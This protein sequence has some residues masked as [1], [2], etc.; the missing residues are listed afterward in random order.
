VT[1]TIEIEDMVVAEIDFLSILYLIGA[2]QGLFFAAALFSKDIGSHVANRYLAL[3]LLAIS[4]SLIDEFFFQSK[5]FIEY[6]HLIGLVWPLDFLYGP[7]FFY[8]L[9]LLTT[10]DVKVASR[11]ELKHFALFGIGIA[12]AIPTWLMSGEDK[13][14]LLYNF[15]TE[16]SNSFSAAVVADSIA[17]LLAI[18]QMLIYLALSFH[19]LNLHQKMMADNFSNLEK[20]NLAWLRSL[21][22][23]FVVLWTLYLF[24]IFFSE[25]LGMG[26]TFGIVLHICLVLMFFT[27]G[28]RG[29]RQHSIFHQ[30][31]ER[32][33][34]IESV[35]L[36]YATSGL[37]REVSPVI[38]DSLHKC[39]LESRPYLKNDLTLAELAELVGVSSHHLSQVINEQFERNYFDFINQFRVQEAEMLLLQSAPKMSVLAIAMESGFNSKT[40]FYEAFKKRTGMTPTQFRKT[41][42]AQR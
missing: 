12:L 36:K 25:S 2:A 8:Y 42:T 9:R 37:S 27:L 11:R 29:M 22:L 31:N 33:P 21:L 16:P 1:G 17:S 13:L 28:F 24:D 30:P 5:Y 4:F 3:L 32:V 14:A 19:R 20:V 6:P 38:A 35:H 39:M 34:S 18:I 41:Y 40:A 10:V 15:P 7:L 26:D 23:L